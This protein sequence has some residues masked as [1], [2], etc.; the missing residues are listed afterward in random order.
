MRKLEE[1]MQEGVQEALMMMLTI[2]AGE[3]DVD[4]IHDINTIAICLLFFSGH[5]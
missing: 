2:V 4:K 5:G 3:D 1:S